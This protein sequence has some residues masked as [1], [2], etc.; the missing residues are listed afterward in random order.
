M[1]FHGAGG[2]AAR[3]YCTAHLCNL[4]ATRA[5]APRVAATAKESEAAS[6]RGRTL[7]HWH[8]ASQYD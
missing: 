1:D 7:V 5:K 4:S 6:S 2:S 8:H 3:R